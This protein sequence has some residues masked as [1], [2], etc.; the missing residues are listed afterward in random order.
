MWK[1]SALLEQVILVRAIREPISLNGNC[2][3]AGLGVIEGFA[4]SPATDSPANAAPGPRHPEQLTMERN[5][6]L[7]FCEPGEVICQKPGP[8]VEQKATI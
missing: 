6:C 7:F 5:A 8:V 4:H 1:Y 2:Q 3:R